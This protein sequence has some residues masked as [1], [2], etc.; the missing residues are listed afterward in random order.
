MERR[1][2]SATVERTKEGRSQ[3]EDFRHFGSYVNHTSIMLVGA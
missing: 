1:K 3:Y 2:D